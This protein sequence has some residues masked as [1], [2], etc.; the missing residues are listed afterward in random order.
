MNQ[1]TGVY[2]LFC[3]GKVQVNLEPNNL[4]RGRE[5]TIAK[6]VA[7]VLFSPTVILPGNTVSFEIGNCSPE[8]IVSQG[9]ILAIHPTNGHN[10]YIDLL[11]LK[12]YEQ[13]REIH[14]GSDRGDGVVR[15]IRPEDKS[16]VELFPAN[17]NS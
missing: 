16:F 5:S 8:T 4:I 17:Q 7:D 11:K 2:T 9:A 14:L 12:E 13:N 3:D 15:Y 10:P 6:M 1:I